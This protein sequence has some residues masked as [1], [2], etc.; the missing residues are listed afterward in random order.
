MFGGIS[1]DASLSSP[2]SEGKSYSRRKCHNVVGTTPSRKSPRLASIRT[3]TD[4]SILREADADVAKDLND[5]VRKVAEDGKSSSTAFLVSP[6]VS[7]PLLSSEPTVNIAATKV[8]AIGDGKIV[9]IA[10]SISPTVVL[11]GN[12]GMASSS[13]KKATIFEGK[14]KFTAIPISLCASDKVTQTPAASENLCISIV[15]SPIA[16]GMPESFGMPPRPWRMSSNVAANIGIPH[17]VSRSLGSVPSQMQK[18]VRE[19]SDYVRNQGVLSRFGLESASNVGSSAT[20]RK[21]VDQGGSSSKK[22]RDNC[23]GMFT[24]TSFNLSS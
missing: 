21:I 23:M 7:Q 17:F 16:K 8:T 11:V 5:R 18:L 9:T 10:I 19:L 14:S 24:P 22:I 6:T 2:S 1:R 4:D 20:K 15:L 12:E 3:N 13:G